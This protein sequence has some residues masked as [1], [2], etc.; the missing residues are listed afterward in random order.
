MR[1]V[2]SY[3]A[4]THLPALL[5]AVEGG[6]TV[7][8]TRNG[9]PSARLVPAGAVPGDART[10]VKDL[11]AFGRRHRGQ[12]RGIHLRDLLDDGRRF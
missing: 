5:D 8:I 2:G 6:E 1:H 7:V 9:R 4:K 11:R 3:E 10:A 12:L